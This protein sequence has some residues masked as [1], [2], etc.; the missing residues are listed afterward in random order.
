MPRMSGKELASKLKEIH[1]NVRVLY[2]S[3]YTVN[4]I[5]GQGIPE[6]A[7]DFLQK[8]FTTIELLA[9]VREILDRP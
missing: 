9:K 6:A 8:P 5:S 7:F 3:G 4:F 2:I 1:P